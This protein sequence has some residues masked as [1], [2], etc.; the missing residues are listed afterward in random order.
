MTNALT[1]RLLEEDTGQDIIEYALLAGSIA[2]V[3]IPTVALLGTAI[4]G[5]FAAVAARLADG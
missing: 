5:V 3:A 1:R 2:V 4:T